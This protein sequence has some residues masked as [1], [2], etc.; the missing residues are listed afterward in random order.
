[1]LCLVLNEEQFLTVIC[2]PNLFAHLQLL[3]SELNVVIFIDSQIW[4]TV[5]YFRVTI[6]FCMFLFGMGTLTISISY[7]VLGLLAWSFTKTG[8]SY[9]HA[10]I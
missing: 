1:M 10:A 8:E 2:V 7:K 9:Y 3:D 6:S 5:L 4:F